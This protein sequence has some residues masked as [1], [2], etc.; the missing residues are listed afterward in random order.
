MF[1]VS[2][3]LESKMRERSKIVVVRC[4]ICAFFVGILSFGQ[5]D[6]NKEERLLFQKFQSL[7]KNFEKAVIYYNKGDVRK[8]KKEF[9]KILE[10]M[11]QYAD[12]RFYMG[13][14]AYKEGDMKTAL[15]LIVK[16]K[17]DY[18]FV[19]K[20]KV[21]MVQML[22]PKLREQRE[23]LLTKLGELEIKL[24][25]E[26]A[27]NSEAVTETQTDRE[28]EK[29]KQEIERIDKRLN[30]PIPT[31]E[32][33][34]ADYFYIHGNIYFKMKKFQEAHDQYQ[35]T[36]RINPKYGRAYNNLAALYFQVKQYQKALDYI[37]QAEAN[38]ATVNPDLKKAVLKALGKK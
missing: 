15:S 10:Q 23:A 3:F 33:L 14:I 4:V 20:M 38:G 28:M 7:N 19:T 17:E 34:P 24:P 9:E 16:A 25:S 13:Q 21:G 31:E 22:E 18:A 8:S 12:A 30:Q 6:F 26:S 37:S 35:E 27:S 36:I 2:D 32:D 29:V 1:L 11:P 5:E